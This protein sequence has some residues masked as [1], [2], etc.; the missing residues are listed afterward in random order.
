VPHSDELDETMV[1]W[2]PTGATTWQTSS[3]LILANW[4]YAI[5]TQ[6]HLQNRKFITYRIFVRGG[7]SRGHRQLTTCTKIWQ[8]S[9]FDI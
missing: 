9:V 7:P 8:K 5:K 6:R 2:R 4:V 3:C 1:V